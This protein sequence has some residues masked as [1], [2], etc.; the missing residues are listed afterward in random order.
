MDGCMSMINNL[1]KHPVEFGLYTDCTTEKENQKAFTTQ[2][3]IFLPLSNEINKS[4]KEAEDKAWTF[5]DK[6]ESTPRVL[7][8]QVGECTVQLS[9]DTGG[10]WSLGAFKDHLYKHGYKD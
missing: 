6:C 4:T 9:Q 8:F 7:F 2:S 3:K 10:S 1:K 5:F